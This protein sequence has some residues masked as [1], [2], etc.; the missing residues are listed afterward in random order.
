M[1][2]LIDL[3]EH[4][5]EW[6]TNKQRGFNSKILQMLVITSISLD[7]PEEEKDANQREQE[8]NRY[9]GNDLI[10]VER[11]VPQTSMEGAVLQSTARQRKRRGFTSKIFYESKVTKGF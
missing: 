11:T 8:A 1:S 5:S 6:R 3:K 2:P 7:V 9:F 10:L 4:L